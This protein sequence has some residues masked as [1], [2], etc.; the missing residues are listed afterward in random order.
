MSEEFSRA[1]KK[2]QVKAVPAGKEEPARS[3]SAAHLFSQMRHSPEKI[4]ELFRT[5]KYPYK[6]KIR[7]SVYEN[8]KAELQVELLLSLIHISE[9]TRQLASSRMPSS[10]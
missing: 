2:V 10:A 5:G 8:H 1:R 9:P 7:R 6:N 4:R 3:D